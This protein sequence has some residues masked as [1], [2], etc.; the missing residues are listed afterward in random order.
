MMSGRIDF[1]M[2]F[3]TRSA[4]QKVSSDRGYRIYILGNFS[5][6]S[7]LSWRQRKI[8][9]IDVD[10][11]DQVMAR[12][13]PALEIGG[14]SMLQFEALDDFHPDAWL[15]KVPILADLQHLK[16]ELSNPATAAQAAA[17]IRA[18]F[19]EGTTDPTPV[20]SQP[21]TESQE[22]MLERL[23]GKRPDSAISETD[24]VARLIERMVS[25]Y[26][27]KEADPQHRALIEVIDATIGQFLRTLLHSQDFQGL[28]ALWRAT[29]ALVNEESADRQSFFLVDIGRAELL[30]ELR[31]GSRAFE[32]QLSQ[33]VQS[34]DDEQ[35][36]LLIGDYGCSDNADDRDLLA[37][38]SQ[39]ANT[40]AGLFLGA[41]D[42]SLIDNFVFA[43]P[44]NRQHWADYLKETRSDK[45]ILAYPR[46]LLRLPYG[47]QRDPIEAFEF[48]ECSAIPQTHELLW[49]NPA[50]LC[51]RA[52]I[53]ASQGSTSEDPFFFGDIPAVT[54]IQDGEPILHP[55]VETLLNEVQANTLLSRG[56][57]PLIGF[58]QRQGVRLIGIST[59]DDHA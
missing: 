22:D 26:V 58:R 38:C 11:F 34:V 19:P 57:M 48:E 43:E 8:H 32:Q 14:G 12:I 56:I 9:K 1:T 10:N 59:L 16:Q 6:R 50:F 37:F 28:E 21:A 53:I 20:Q 4:V 2:G 42:K 36:V 27:A 7:D 47:K 55:S 49:G 3:N 25:P 45:V 17:K 54:F 33:H 5:G 40:C 30:A 13:M 52:L 46:Y 29:E 23:L 41:A 39:L 31:S 18:Y 44:E 51:A 15:E 24:S 35:D